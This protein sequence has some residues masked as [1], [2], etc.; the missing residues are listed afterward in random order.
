MI[1][2]LYSIYIVDKSDKT[3]LIKVINSCHVNEQNK[4][5][6]L[7]YKNRWSKRYQVI[8][9]MAFIACPDFMS[10]TEVDMKVRRGILQSE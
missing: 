6:S 7:I 9:Q 3:K 5:K 2:L 10:R 8:F 1:D 4:E